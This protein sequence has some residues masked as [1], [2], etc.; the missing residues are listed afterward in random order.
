MIISYFC[1]C[2]FI[3]LRE[4]E[5]EN[6]KT[7]LCTVV[8]YTHFLIFLQL[9][10]IHFAFYVGYKWPGPQVKQVAS[11]CTVNTWPPRCPLDPRSQVL[12]PHQD[13]SLKPPAEKLFP[14]QSRSDCLAHESR[15]GESFG[16][17]TDLW[18]QTWGCPQQLCSGIRGC[19]LTWAVGQ[20]KVLPYKAGVYHRGE[21]K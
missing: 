15:R 6:L 12:G 14:D 21:G 3:Y 18:G 19:K 8:T 4:R 5:R 11:S 1:I 17:W 10:K 13:M 2:I 9:N 7:L 20:P 16:R